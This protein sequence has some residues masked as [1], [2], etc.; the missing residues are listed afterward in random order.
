MDGFGCRSPHAEKG[1]REI[2]PQLAKSGL[3]RL[4]VVDPP[5]PVY[6]IQPG[7]T[8]FFGQLEFSKIAKQDNHVLHP[9]Q[10]RRARAAG[11]QMRDRQRRRRSVQIAVKVFA[12]TLPHI[13]APHFT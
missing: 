13:S 5:P 12:Q 4:S 1:Y 6:R 2:R 7:M 8:Q 11:V 9:F 10:N 3:R